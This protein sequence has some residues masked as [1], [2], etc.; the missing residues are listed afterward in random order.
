MLLENYSAQF[1]QFEIDS[2]Q[3]H[4]MLEPMSEFTLFM[5]RNF[6]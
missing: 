3:A 4:S 5:I 2:G 1:S 6:L